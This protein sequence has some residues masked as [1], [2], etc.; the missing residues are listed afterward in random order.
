L[1][2]IPYSLPIATTLMIAAADAEYQI[3]SKQLDLQTPESAPRTEPASPP[4]FLLPNCLLHIP[5]SLP[6]AT[7]LMIAATGADP[8]IQSSRIKARS[9]PERFLLQP[10]RPTPP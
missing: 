6:I 3:S 9:P 2:H 5:Y 7:T 4:Q 8:Q 1:L 10:H